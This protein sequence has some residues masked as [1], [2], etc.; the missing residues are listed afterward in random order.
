V[1][2]YSFSKE[3]A[4]PG[5]R[6]W[7]A[8]GHPDLV[9]EMLKIMDCVAICAP[10]VGQE[11]AIAGLT[12][13]K[14]WRREKAVEMYGR[15]SAFEML[16]AQRPGH[17]ALT[18]AGA[19]FGWVRHPFVGQSATDVA[20]RL[21]TEQGIVSLPGTIFSTEGEA[22]LRMSFSGLTLTDFGEVGE[23]LSTFGEIEQSKN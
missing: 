10:R 13:C 5:Y 19:L 12:R 17:F 23:R 6:V 7:A 9:R 8:V 21:V 3:F 16:L 11:A 14:D 4:I 15:Q 1:F 18:S 20:Q 2:L 22:Y